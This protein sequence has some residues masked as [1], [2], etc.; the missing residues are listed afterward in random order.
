MRDRSI[1]S[2]FVSIVGRLHGIKV[3]LYNQTAIISDVRVGINKRLWRTLFPR[4][5]MS[6]VLYRND[7]NLQKK[8]VRYEYALKI[9][10]SYWIPFVTHN[11]LDYKIKTFQNKIRILSVARFSPYKNHEILI[12]ALKRLIEIGK[13]IEL[14]IVGHY[15]QSDKKYYHEIISLIDSFSLSDNVRIVTSVEYDDMINYYEW[16]DIFV[17]TSKRELA[18]VAVA[19]AI[20]NG[21]AV[22][23]TSN[24]GTASYIIHGENGLIFTSDDLDSLVNQ[25]L[26]LIDNHDLRIRMSLSG[27]RFA[28]EY[29]HFSKFYDFLIA[30]KE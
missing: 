14:T 18:S 19:E 12:K 8:Q 29:F 27:V 24:N 9:K 22:I 25:M 20:T 1:F 6:P 4:N 17:L 26:L 23:S 11:G 15:I 28:R 21:V 2:L 7:L 10:Y 30:P 3:I 5:V 13:S 16:A